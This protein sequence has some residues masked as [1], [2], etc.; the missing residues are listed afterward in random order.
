MLLGI[1]VLI[2]RREKRDIFLLAFLISLY[3]ILHRDLIG[4]TTFLHR[5]LSASAHI[6]IPITVIGALSIPSIVNSLIRLPLLYKNMLKYAAAILIISLTLIYNMP[7]AY[8][9]LSQVYQSPLFRLT[10]SQIEVSEWL[11]SSIAEDQNVSVLGQIEGAPFD[12]IKKVWW[13]ASYSHRTSYFFE[14]FLKWKTYEE[15]RNETIQSHLLNDYIVVDYTDIILLGSQELANN[16][17]AFERDVLANHT[18][19]YNKNNIRVYKYE[20]N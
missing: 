16:L 11:K 8:S 15:N 3:L 19:L 18:L 14:G 9:T 1:L 4:K 13:M 10:P 2:V 7:T 6:F 17:Q 5:S 20:K 12:T